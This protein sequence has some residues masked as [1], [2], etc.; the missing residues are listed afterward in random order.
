MKSTPAETKIEEVPVDIPIE[1][2]IEEVPAKQV[3]SK[4]N[5]TKQVPIIVP[6]K[7]VPTIIDC[8]KIYELESSITKLENVVHVPEIQEKDDVIGPYYIYLILRMIVQ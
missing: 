1:T 6:T 8:G 3:K 5:P 4:K 7:Q 2:K